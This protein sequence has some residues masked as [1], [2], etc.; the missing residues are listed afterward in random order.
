M[1]VSAD[2]VQGGT[3]HKLKVRNSELWVS[4]CSNAALYFELV[5]CRASI[6]DAAHVVRCKVCISISGINSRLRLRTISTH[7]GSS[8]R[9]SMS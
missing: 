3:V 8:A 5:L 6:L 7:D 9:V 4:E 1:G 2:K